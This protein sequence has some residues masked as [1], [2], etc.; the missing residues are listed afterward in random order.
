M[1]AIRKEKQKLTNQQLLAK[2]KNVRINSKVK[3]SFPINDLQLSYR[4]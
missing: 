1:E 3:I 2:R 4:R